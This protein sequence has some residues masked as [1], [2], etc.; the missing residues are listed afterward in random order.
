MIRIMRSPIAS[1]L[2]ARLL[3][4]TQ[5]I[6]DVCLCKRTAYA[7]TVWD[8][9]TVRRDVHKPLMGVLREM[10]PGI[11]CCMYCGDHLADTIDH[12]VPKAKCPTRTFQWRNLLLACSPCNSRYKGERFESDGLVGSLLID[13]TLEDPLD[14]LHLSLA[15]GHYVPIEGSIK[16][17]WTIKVCGLNKSNRPMARVHAWETMREGVRVWARAR[18]ERDWKKMS[19]WQ[20]L[21]KEQPFADVCHSALRQA[22]YEQADTCFESI[23][24]DVVELLR[25]EELRSALLAP[26]SYQS[27]DTQLSST[28]L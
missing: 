9:H 21:M 6:V 28:S 25:D 7:R 15:T 16:G 17:H 20:R 4:L 14:H 8:R 27:S 13:P 11:D 18:Q 1:E 3:K 12:F 23:D 10:A 5:E 24:S 2:E 22:R 26:K 19:I